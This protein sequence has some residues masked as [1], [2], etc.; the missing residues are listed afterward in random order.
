M[1][2]G[3]F[4]SLGLYFA[5]M[6]GIGLFAYRNS[7]ANVEGYLLGGRQLSPAVT[8]LSAGASDMSGWM[9]M[10]VPGAMFIAGMSSSWIGIG[11]VIGAWCNYKYVAPRL[12]V[13]TEVANNAITIP[14]YFSERF[15]DTSHV[16]RIISALVII[17]FFTLYTSSGVVAGGK[18]FESSFGLD[19][20]LG[21]FITAGVV[22]AYTL[23]GGF[24]AVSL[25]DFVQGCIMFIALILVPTV[26]VF[27]LGGINHT[28]T[29]INA[30]DPNYFSLFNA[31]GSMDSIGII[32][33]ISLMAWGLG[34][35]GQPHII[36]RFMALRDVKDMPVA[37]R[38]GMSWMIIALF[39][40]FATG[41]F[42]M[43]YA[44]EN[45]LQVDDPETI[46]IMLSQL[47]F[48]PLIAGFLL[49]AIL[50][51]IM[52]TISSQLLVTSS[53]L[54]NDIYEVVLRKD[55]TQ[56][57]LVLASR[58]AVLAVAIVA[59]LLALGEN[60]SILSLVSNAWAGFGAAFGPLILLSLYR[61]DISKIAALAGI[62]SGTVTIL[63]WMN[64]P[65]GDG[66]TLSAW[67]FEL[68]PGFVISTMMILLFTKLYPNSEPMVAEHFKAMNAKLKN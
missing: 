51:A 17:L 68:L 33:I 50:A 43:V 46:F 20:Q 38:I 1:D 55:A 59:I 67:M 22:V 25:T 4:V 8:A 61:Q 3:V 19:Y 34:Y 21:V 57:E 16:L 41:L 45:N 63:I 14:D 27:E 58:L 2:T 49:A 42:G 23:F 64:I 39:G 62:I 60:K 56:Q 28:I 10:G 24:M 29:A 44:T 48:H 35:F 13:Y 26:V 66:Q 31:V 36:V 6:L 32:A 9:L 65:Y 18:L 5:V 15:I 52:S 53:S 47:L 54:V 11:L 37:R 40:A 12:R 7:E 30:I